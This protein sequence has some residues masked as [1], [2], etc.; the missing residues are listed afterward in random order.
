MPGGYDVHTQINKYMFF[1]CV[2]VCVFMCT[3]VYVCMTTYVHARIR[4]MY[5]CVL[6]YFCLHVRIHT[7]ATLLNCNINSIIIK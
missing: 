5:N 3:Y 1:M 4:N 7:C 6:F 2:Y